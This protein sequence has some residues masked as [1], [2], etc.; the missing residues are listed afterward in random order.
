MMLDL[1]GIGLPIFESERI[2]RLIYV[3]G[4]NGF[5]GEQ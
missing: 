1:R 3:N 2:P 4:K 5:S